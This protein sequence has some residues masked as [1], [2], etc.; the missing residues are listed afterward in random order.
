[1]CTCALAFLNYLTIEFMYRLVAK[2]TGLPS[3]A[4]LLR[5]YAKAEPLKITELNN[6]IITAPTQV[7]YLAV[8][9]LDFWMM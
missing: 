6:F 1:M 7:K 2:D 8:S 5:G 4:P 9:F 3:A